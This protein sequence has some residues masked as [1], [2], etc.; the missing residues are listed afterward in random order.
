MKSIVLALCAALTAAPALSQ[1]A[2]HIPLLRLQSSDP[3]ERR[4]AC[5]LLASAAHRGPQAYRALLDTMRRD[6]SERVRLSAAAGIIT[7]PGTEPIQHVEA[8]FKTEPGP[9]VRRELLIALST[10]PTRLGD[11]EATRLIASL[12]AEDQ[13][14]EVR[15]TAAD[16]L[17]Q[18]PG[19]AARTALLAAS[20]ADVDKEVRSL[21][22][23]SLGALLSPPKT[24]KKSS[25]ALKPPKADAVFGVDSCL[26]PWGWCACVGAVRLKPKCVTKDECRDTRSEMRRYDMTCDWDGQAPD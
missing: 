9:A 20:R 11:S 17:G 16:I 4:V 3:S 15:R 14:A 18:R 23:R 8:F 13:S 10:E 19:P 7:F 12:L 5:A 21:A 1:D 26:P 24:K 25:A 6:L 22:L 2:E